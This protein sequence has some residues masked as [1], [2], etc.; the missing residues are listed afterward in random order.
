[1]PTLRPFLALILP[2]LLATT[3]AGRDL[4][5]NRDIR[6]ILS[7]NCF[8][9]HGTDAKKRKADLRLDDENSAKAAREGRFAIKPGDLKVSELWQRI[10]SPD[11]DEVMPPPKSHKTL[12][13]AQK[14]TLRLWIVQGAKYQRHWS[15]EPPVKPA[16]PSDLKAGPLDAFLLARLKQEGLA[17]SPPA[18]QATLIRRVTLDLTGLPP[19]PGE[20]AAFL[21]D[22]SPDAY[23]KLVKR[24]LAS[25]RF[26]EHMAH[27]WLDLARYGDTHGLHLDNERQMWL[28]RDWVV[29]AFNRNLPFDQFTIEQIA[30][31][32]IPGAAAAQKVASGFNR[33]NVTTGEGGSIDAEQLFRYASERAATTMQNWLGLTGQCAACHDH[34]FDPITQKDYY[35]MYAFF[36][37]SADPA[38][39]KNTLLVNPVM[40]FAPPDKL[41]QLETLKSGLATNQQRFA[42][43]LKT[44]AYQDPAEAVPPPKLERADAVW[45]DDAFPA[46]A[47]VKSK[48]KAPV[49]LV[50]DPEIKPASGGRALKRLAEG[51]GEDAYQ[52]DAAPIVVPRNAIIQVMVRLSDTNLPKSVMLKFY[53]D[54]WKHRAVWGDAAA[55][56]EG[57]AGA[58]E[59]FSAGPLPKPGEWVKLEVPAGKIG[60]K[61]GDQITGFSFAQFG[62]LVYWDRLAVAG[63]TSAADDPKLSFQAWQQVKGK[64]QTGVP[65]DIIPLLNASPEKLTAEQTAKLR[66]HFLINVCKTTQPTMQPLVGAIAAVEKEVKDFDGT[67][68]STY[69]MGEV[70]KPRQA[71]IMQRGAYDK[72]GQPVEPQ[73]PA[74]LP[75]LPATVT[76]RATRLDLAKWIVSPENPLAAR[77]AVN[78]FWQHFFGLGLVKTSSDFGSQGESPSHAEALDFLAVT[79]RESGWDMKQL[80]TTLVTSQAYHQSSDTRDALLNQDPENRLL[81][82]SPRLRLNAEAIR[83]QALYVSDL[84]VEKMGGKAVRTYQ[85]PNI[86][87][88]V[89]YIDSNTRKYKQDSGESLYRRSLYV[90]IKRTA[91]AP[92]LVNFDAPSREAFCSRRDRGNTPLQALQLLNDVQYFEAA[93]AFAQRLLTKGGAT[94][95]ERIAFGFQCAVNR[96]PDAQE[97]GRVLAMLKGFEEKYRAQ[98]DL[99]KKVIAVGESK[100]DA[101]LPPAELAAW[102]QVANLLLNLDETIV[103]P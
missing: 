22:K 77:V 84:L 49:A 59:P 92:F 86:W 82:R 71:H 20:V 15:F 81:A 44:L 11:E 75:P 98:P 62:G 54:G 96:A 90:F 23:A 17:F 76:N 14:E 35:S 80:I 85:P 68:P 43:A 93:R 72:P 13:A 41:R 19:H 89:G 95:Q 37:S 8:A 7:E 38:S 40:K 64:S 48:G 24:L 79:F 57:I 51:F 5:F 74:F 33:C 58:P 103:R 60:L 65:K 16:P 99:A 36:Y 55:I 4:S 45:M 78:R 32:L 52:G 21:A 70:P 63:E 91:P 102:T 53:S 94:P 87:E 67:L 46:K 18:D 12:S 39:D 1:M 47:K 2:G 29:E 88:P 69:I 61:A 6:P 73:T 83:D 26:G 97:A 56:S 50:G 66:E 42:A 30:G 28:Y 27:W 10:N 25:P 101:A 9:C 100:P 34:K 3:A 31:D